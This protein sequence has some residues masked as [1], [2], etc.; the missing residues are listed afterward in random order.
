MQHHIKLHLARVVPN[1][2]YLVMTTVSGSK[3]TRQSAKRKTK[4]E[5]NTK[6]NRLLATTP[7]IIDKT[8]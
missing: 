5:G 6:E 7:S 1:G 2:T 3:N 4:Q 8:E